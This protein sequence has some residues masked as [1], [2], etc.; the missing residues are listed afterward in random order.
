[1]LVLKAKK[2]NKQKL[3]LTRT[4][5]SVRGFFSRLPKHSLVSSRSS[6][7]Q[8]VFEEKSKTIGIPKLGELFGV[9]VLA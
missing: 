4:F 9:R 6:I 1:M 7:Y 8:S 3:I 2:I 5:F